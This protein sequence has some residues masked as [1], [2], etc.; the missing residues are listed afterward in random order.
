MAASFVG[1]AV[2]I[3]ETSWRTVATGSSLT[4]LAFLR[5]ANYKLSSIALPCSLQARQNHLSRAF[6]FMSNFLSAL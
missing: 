6:F 2:F 1:E 4:S 3:S 5:G